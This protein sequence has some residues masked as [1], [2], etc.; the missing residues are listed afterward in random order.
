M[1][2]LLQEP[3]LDTGNEGRERGEHPEAGRCARYD[4]CTH[5]QHQDI[6]AAIALGMGASKERRGAGG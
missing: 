6:W 1:Q 2:E 4:R 5:S 3:A